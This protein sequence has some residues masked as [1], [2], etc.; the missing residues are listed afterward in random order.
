MFDVG[1]FELLLIGVIG[2]LVFGPEQFL[3]AVRSTVW[4]FKRIRRSFDDVR[5]EV[6][7]EI[8]NDQVMRNLRRDAK[9]VQQEFKNTGDSFNFRPEEVQADAQ[10]T[11]NRISDVL[12]DDFRVI[13]DESTDGDFCK[14]DDSLIGES[15]ETTH[16]E[17]RSQ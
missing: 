16:N 5:A 8:H 17:N 6:Q 11:V 15:S 2:L 10:N 13:N 14:E 7:Q 4:W 12:D 1:F 9:K 3:D